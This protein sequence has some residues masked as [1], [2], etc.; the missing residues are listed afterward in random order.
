MSETR[1]RTHIQVSG[2]IGDEFAIVRADLVKKYKRDPGK[3]QIMMPLFPN[4]LETKWRI[5]F[6][7]CHPLSSQLQYS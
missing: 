3:K 4:S 1:K 5:Q 2:P 6:V 7:V